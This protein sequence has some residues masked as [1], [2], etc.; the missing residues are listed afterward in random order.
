MQ[1]IIEL[2]NGVEIKLRMLL[3]S[4]RTPVSAISYIFLIKLKEQNSSW[5][6]NYIK[7]ILFFSIYYNR[8]K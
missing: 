7:Y 1:M 8:F 3:L 5:L 4:K 6:V 2:V